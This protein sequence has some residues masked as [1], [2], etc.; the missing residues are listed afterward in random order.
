MRGTEAGHI[1]N[2]PMQNINLA[3]LPP[4]MFRLTGFYCL[5]KVFALVASSGRMLDEPLLPRKVT[6]VQLPMK[7][8]LE[9]KL[10]IV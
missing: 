8:W 10:K 7:S 5:E 4:Q 6:D 2:L 1:Y 9:P 3:L